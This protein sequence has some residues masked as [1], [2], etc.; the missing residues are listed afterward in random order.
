M[1]NLIFD[2]NITGHHLEYLYHYHKGA[3]QRKDEKFVFC[4]EEEFQKVKAEYEWLESENVEFSFMSKDECSNHGVLRR[5][6]KARLIARKAKEYGADRVILT[7]FIYL[8]PFLLWAMPKGK[9]VRGIIYRI[10]LYERERMSKLRR[11][12]DN[13]IYWLMA[14]SSAM[15]KVFILND[16]DSANELNSMY[17]TKKFSYLPD[18]IPTVDMSQ[19]RDVREN[20]QIP[21]GN[22]MFLHFGGLT[23]RKGTLE[24]LKAIDMLTDEQLKDK[25]FVFAGRV[26]KEMRDEFYVL[27]KQV[28]AR[29]QVVVLDGFCSYNLL[30]NLCY[31]CD[32][33]LMPYQQTNLSSGVLGYA[34]VFGK[35]VIGP[36]DGLLGN[37]IRKFKMGICLP[38]V[39]AESIVKTLVQPASCESHN[40]AVRNDV[41]IFINSILD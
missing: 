37:L 9:K 36:T 29:T 22:R 11:I 7:N 23:Q 40:Y 13:L 39:Y 17:G 27:V 28:E 35:P 32:A 31:S 20:Y 1:T 16:E 34:S 10:F 14:K 15:E 41:Q 8:I 26:Y 3:L 19:L 5:W 38:S 4:L 6:A 21:A 30:Y 33:I 25:T 12:A 24:I 2:E 18:P